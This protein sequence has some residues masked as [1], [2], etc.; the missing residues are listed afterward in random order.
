MEVTKICKMCGS[1]FMGRTNARYCCAR[2]RTDYET[3]YARKWREANREHY[4]EYQKKYQKG[5]VKKCR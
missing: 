5:L 1:E 2:C 4:K 3:A